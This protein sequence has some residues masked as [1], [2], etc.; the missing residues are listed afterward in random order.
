MID[1]KDFEDIR[2]KLEKADNEREELIK[3]SRDLLKL[4]KQVIYSVQRSDMG[5]A[6]NLIAKIKKEY[7]LLKGIAEKNP[8]LLYSGSFKVAVQEYVEA[9]SFFYIFDKGRL[10][11]H[12]ELDTL[13]GYYLLGIC[14]FV[15]E[16]VRKAVNET[17]KGREK[18]ALQIKDIVDNIYAEFMLFDIRNGELRKK[19]D[20]IKYDLSR[21][22][23]MALGIKL[24]K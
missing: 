13:P 16:L 11:T 15:G 20:G 24:K 18:E 9:L 14:D 7:T 5:N 8:E 2:R 10:P 12:K 22:N 6:K 21:L 23:D 17:I 4:S 1:K 3:K 19:V